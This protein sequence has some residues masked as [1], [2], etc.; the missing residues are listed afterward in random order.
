MLKPLSRNGTFP[1]S[2]A[3]AAR[4]REQIQNPG[5]VSGSAGL[6]GTARAGAVSGS[7]GEASGSVQKRSESVL[8]MHEVEGDGVRTWRRVVV[9]YR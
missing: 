6:S 3:V 5:K 7:N 8:Q 4:A 2:G 1:S 9:E